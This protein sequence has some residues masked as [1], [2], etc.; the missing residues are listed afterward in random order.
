MGGPEH[1]E[2]AGGVLEEEGA[3]ELLAYLICSARTQLDEAAEYAPLRLLTAAGRLAQMIEPQASSRLRALLDEVRRGHAETSVAAGDP[4]GYADRLDALCRTLA[5]Y[6]LDSL[7][8]RAATNSATTN[9][10]ATNSGAT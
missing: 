3:V 10:G 7:D 5:A 8:P 6:L 9:D 1:T 4:Q 2:R